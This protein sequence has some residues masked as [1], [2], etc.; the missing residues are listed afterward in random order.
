MF[1]IGDLFTVDPAHYPAQC[2]GV[3][4]RVTALPRGATGVNY[5][6]A[7]M[8]RTDSGDWIPRGGSGVRAPEWAMRKH[9]PA[10]EFG[11][12]PKFVPLPDRA[13]L[14]RFKDG[15]RPPN[16]EDALYIVTGFPQRVPNAVQLTK[17]GGDNG[18]YWKA[19][20][21]ERLEVIDYDR[22]KIID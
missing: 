7:A 9:D 6:G 19:V 1:A 21:I 8:Q 17:L 12:A 18:R 2:H 16:V 11:A 3:V 20:D 5:K 4:Y 22:V 15:Q 13:A 10:E 14:V